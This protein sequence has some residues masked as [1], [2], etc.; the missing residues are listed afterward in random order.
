MSKAIGLSV[1]AVVNPGI[2]AK[3]A[4]FKII[5][6]STS[7]DK[8]GN[9]DGMYLLQHDGNHG[10]QVFAVG[11]GLESS[12]LADRPEGQHGSFGCVLTLGNTETSDLNAVAKQ[13]RDMATAIEVAAHTHT[14]ES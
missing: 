10:V 6:A 14:T 2:M 12:V 1:G 11:T 13:L 4:E 8:D 9:V 3:E 5:A 7:K